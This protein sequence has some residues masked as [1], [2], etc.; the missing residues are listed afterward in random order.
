MTV[1]ETLIIKTA[2]E[3]EAEASTTATAAK[4]ATTNITAT[5]EEAMSATAKEKIQDQ[6]GGLEFRIHQCWQW[7]GEY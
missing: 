3:A 5:T 2:T 6:G 1:V 7:Y 4:E